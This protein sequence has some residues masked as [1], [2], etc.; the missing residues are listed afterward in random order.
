MG[1]AVRAAA[2]MVIMGTK[3]LANALMLA[4]GIIEGAARFLI[5]DRMHIT[6]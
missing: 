4:T 2:W 3:G 1:N 6:G 5:K